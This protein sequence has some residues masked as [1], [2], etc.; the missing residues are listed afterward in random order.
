MNQYNL[1]YQNKDFKLSAKLIH[2]LTNVNRSGTKL[3]LINCMRSNPKLSLSLSFLNL[4][5]QVIILRC[6]IDVKVR[7]SH[8]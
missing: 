6:Q 2:F 3:Y 5:D 7:H 8:L 4:H 1:N